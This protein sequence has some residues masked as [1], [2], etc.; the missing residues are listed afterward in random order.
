MCQACRRL[1]LCRSQ[2]GLVDLAGGFYRRL[3]S[4]RCLCLSA[5]GQGDGF[6]LCR[7]TAADALEWSCFANSWEVSGWG[8]VTGDLQDSGNISPHSPHPRPRSQP[9]WLCSVGWRSLEKAGHLAGL[10]WP[11]TRGSGEERGANANSLGVHSA[12]SE[13]SFSSV[14]GGLASHPACSFES[15]PHCPSHILLHI[16]G[17]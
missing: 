17:G 5:E 16:Q 9:P 6:Q 10:E 4:D 1:R 13:C 12:K 3:D 11:L 2:P 8:Q 15:F 14:K 7:V